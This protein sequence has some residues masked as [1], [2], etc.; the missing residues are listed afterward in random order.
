MNAN[1]LIKLHEQVVDSWSRHDAK[2]LLA[3]MDENIVFHDTGVPGPINGKAEL[4]KY[5]NA[6]VAAFPDY[7]MK[8][9]N[10]VVSDDYI[11]AE[12]EGSGTNKGPLSMRDQP[13]MPATNR[14]LTSRVSYFAKVKNGKIID[15]YIYSDVAGMMGQLGLQEVH[16]AHA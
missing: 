12:I 11:A 9:L 15:V 16:E 3:L 6:W 5:F 7:K 4:E 13:E 2:K 10:T 1:D 8:T 14:K